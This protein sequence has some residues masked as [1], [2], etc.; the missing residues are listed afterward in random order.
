MK[1][2]L[3]RLT[4]LAAT[5]TLCVGLIGCSGDA[6]V[7]YPTDNEIICNELTICYASPEYY[8]YAELAE[9]AAIII[10]ADVL[11]LVRVDAQTHTDCY[12]RVK[13]REVLKG[14]VRKREVL[15]VEQGGFIYHGGTGGTADGGPLMEE[16]NRVVLFLNDTA[17]IP[18]MED[19]KETTPDGDILY[20]Q[21][22]L[23]LFFLDSDGKYHAS[24]TY[25]ENYPHISIGV[26]LKDPAPKTL[27]EIK[28]LIEKPVVCDLY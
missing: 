24:K 25:N 20:F 23:G 16:G 2:I 7:R 11:E 26:R 28:V 1:S 10:E 27:G 15:C 14:D 18:S 22:T 17:E 6:A 21:S 13:V 3:S 19:F 5:L 9:K 4:V 12:A 8:S